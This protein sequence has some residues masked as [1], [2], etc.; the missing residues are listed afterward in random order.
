MVKIS[1]RLGGAEIARSESERQGSV[2]LN[3]FQAKIDY[4]YATANTTYG[5]I[6]VRV[7]V[8]HGRYEEEQEELINA[9]GTK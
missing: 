7:W 1:G 4:G 2:P 5:I 8:H 3:Q 6:G 9:I